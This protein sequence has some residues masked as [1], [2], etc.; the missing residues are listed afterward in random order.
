MSVRFYTEQEN[1]TLKYV[2]EVEGT[3][4]PGEAREALFD[5]IPRLAKQDEFVLI[6]SEDGDN[7]S[8]V[9]TRLSKQE[10]VQ[11]A[12]VTGDGESAG[13]DDNEDDDEAEEEP[14]PKPKRSAPKRGTKRK[15]PARKPAAKKGTTRKP[16]AKKT[17]AKKAPAKKASG[18][19]TPFTRN[20]SSDE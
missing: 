6:I 15:A 19:R 5:A 4:D 14:A 1:G 3:T 7:T 10:V 11:T 9:M 8:G 12:W 16:P 13:G 17:S 20:A 2:E 18:K